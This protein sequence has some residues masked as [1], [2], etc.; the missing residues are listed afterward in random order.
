MTTLEEWFEIL[1]YCWRPPS[2][3]QVRIW[4]VLHEGFQGYAPWNN[5]ISSNF[6][7][8]FNN[9]RQ[10]WRN[11]LKFGYHLWR[12]HLCPMN[13][14]YSKFYHSM[15]AVSVWTEGNNLC[16]YFALSQVLCKIFKNSLNVCVLSHA[17]C[18][19]SFLGFYESF[20]VSWLVHKVGA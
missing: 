9:F 16:N 18:Y 20:G 6:R 7:F 5:Q 13:T 19:G 14:F 2:S 15:P 11:D 1:I 12:G 10:H 17:F 8:P 3:D 4:R